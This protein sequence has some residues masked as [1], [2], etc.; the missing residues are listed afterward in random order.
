MIIIP[1]DRREEFPMKSC[2][3]S[4][5]MQ[6]EDQTSKEPFEGSSPSNQAIYGLTYEANYEGFSNDIECGDDEVENGNSNFLDL[7]RNSIKRARISSCASSMQDV[8]RITK[9]RI[10]WGTMQEFHELG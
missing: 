10:Q 1:K 4:R 9:K 8:R 3:K 7:A 5:S 2:L 6:G